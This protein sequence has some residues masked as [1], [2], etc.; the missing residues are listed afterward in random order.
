MGAAQRPINNTVQ[1]VLK[2]LDMQVDTINS[3]V[4]RE[5]HSR[6]ELFFGIL[7]CGGITQS[8]ANKYL[9]RSHALN[10]IITFI[11]FNCC[12]LA[13]VSYSSIDMGRALVALETVCF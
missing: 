7:W 10:R 2:F 1:D 4:L 13:E 9:F 8:Q 3:T 5:N 11:M 6:L 12:C